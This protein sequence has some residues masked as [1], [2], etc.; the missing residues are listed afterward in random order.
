MSVAGTDSAIGN[1]DNNNILFTIKDTKLYVPVGTLSARD[2]QKL[3]KRLSKG[4]ERS[5]YWNVC[6]TK[7]E[8]KNTTTEY[9]YFYESKFVGVNRLFGLV[10]RNEDNN[11]KRFNAWKYYLPKCIIKNNNLIIDGKNLYDQPIDSDIKR[12]EDIRKLTTRKDEVYTNGCFL[13]CHCIKNDY[14]LTSV[15]LSRQ[16]QLDANPKVIQQIE[17]AG[18]LK[19]LNGNDNATDDGNDKSM[20]VLTILEKIKR[21]D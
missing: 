20:F 1:N 5:V 4:F 13:D 2:N 7:S 9:R 3:P 11:A 19:K 18:Q 21:H 8:N 10:N 16:K 12:Y 6:K 14:R 15:D 17:F